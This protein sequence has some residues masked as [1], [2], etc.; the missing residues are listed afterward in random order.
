M[1]LRK[2]KKNKQKAN[3]HPNV[4]FFFFIENNCRVKCEW[5]ANSQSIKEIIKTTSSFCKGVVEYIRQFSPCGR[6]SLQ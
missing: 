2:Q 5:T 3:F 4:V 1:A 6:G